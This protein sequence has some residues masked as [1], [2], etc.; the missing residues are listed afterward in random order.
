MDIKVHK[1]VDTEFPKSAPPCKIAFVAE[2]PGVD[3]A[4]KGRPLI[5]KSGQ[6]F[7]KALSELGIDR[8]DCLVG[9][10]FRRRPFENDVSFFFMKK[11]EAKKARWDKECP[12]PPFG[13]HGYVKPEWVDE[14]YRLKIELGT[15]KPNIVVGMGATALWALTGEDKIGAHRGVVLPST[16]IEGMKVLTTWHPAAILRMWHFLPQFYLDID[17][18][19]RESEFPEIRHTEREIWI[20]PDL[21]DLNRFYDQEIRQLREGNSPLSY[22]IETVPGNIT[23][24]GFSPRPEVSLV[25]PFMDKRKVDWSYWE[26]S[27]QEKAAWGWVKMV[28]EDPTIPKVAQNG[29]YDMQWLRD[30]YGIKVRGT[31]HD[32]MLMHHALQPELQKSL[33]FMASMYLN[34]TSWKTFVNF[35]EKEDA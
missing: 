18:A 32:T 25:I 17:K 10:V 11:G 16:L 28:L 34:E 35:K 23:C 27:E 6:L 3:E 29:M 31:P 22:D 13:S 5:G 14:V 4:L 2:A 9:N 8:S 24:I 20:E 30:H 33:G 15:F 19:R 26:T 21:R 1:L 12:F 7:N